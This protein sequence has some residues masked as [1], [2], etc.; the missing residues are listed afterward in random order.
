MKKRCQSQMELKKKNIVILYH[1][2]FCKEMDE[3][4]LV[5]HMIELT[6][7]YKLRKKEVHVYLFFQEMVSEETLRKLEKKI[8]RG[9]NV[10]KFFH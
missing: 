1:H 2:R 7:L 6:E 4:L 8:V 10:Y 9:I 5:S 3:E